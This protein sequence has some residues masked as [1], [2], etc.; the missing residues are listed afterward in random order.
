MYIQAY[1]PECLQKPTI[2]IVLRTDEHIT[3]IDSKL[4]IRS[5]RVL[6]IDNLGRSILQLVVR[7]DEY[8]T[9]FLLKHSDNIIACYQV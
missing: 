3:E 5:W 9:L 7:E 2:K 1:G 8:S 6:G 4:Y